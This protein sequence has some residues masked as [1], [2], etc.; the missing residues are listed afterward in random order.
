MNM[1]KVI[2]WSLLL[3]VP[4]GSQAQC[5][6]TVQFPVT[7]TVPDA[8]GAATVIST[9][10]FAGDYAL[11]ALTA[12]QIYRFSSSVATDHITVSTAVA[13]GAVAFGTQPVL[14]TAA[15]TQAY[16]VHFHTNAACGTQSV[17]RTTRVQRVYC[18]AGTTSCG[19]TNESIARVTIGAINNLSGGCGGGGYADFSAQIATISTGQSESITVVNTNP[20]AG[21]QVRVF[22]D[23]NL[24]FSLN[25]AGETY[26]LATTD[27]I[28]FSGS[29]TA[30][31]GTLPGNVRMR[32]RLAYTGTVPTCGNTNF[33]EVEDYTLSVCNSF[34][35][36]SG[37]GDVMFAI[38]PPYINRFGGG[39]GRGDAQHTIQGP[40]PIVLSD[41]GGNTSFC[42]G[43]SFQVAYVPGG[44]HN[45]GN[46]F[47]VQLSNAAGSFT[48]QVPV[49]IGS[50]TSTGSGSIP[51][52]IPV[53]TPAGTGYRLRVVSSNPVRTGFA[54]GTAITVVAGTTW[55]A[56][57]D[58]DGFGNPAATLL[59]C[60]QPNGYVANN[61]DN[62]PT[63]PL[64]T[65]PGICGCGV[66]DCPV[67]TVNVSVEDENTYF[68]NGAPLVAGAHVVIYDLTTSVIFADGFSNAAGVFSSSNIP[69]GTR[70]ISV[71]A[72]GHTSAQVAIAVNSGSTLNTAV[73]IS[74]TSG[75]DADNDGFFAPYD[76]N[77]ADPNINPGAAE[78]CSD[79]LDNDCDGIVNELFI[80]YAD[81]DGDGFGDPVVDSIACSTPVGYVANNTDNCPAV[82][83]V[84]GSACND[85]NANTTNDVLSASC[86]CTGTPTAVT[87]AA[88]VI[89]E[90]PYN[91]TTGLMNDDLRSLGTF[92]LADPY[93]ALG[94]VHTG[95][96]T[97]GPVA[98]AVIAVSGTDAIVDWVLLELR[99]T[100]NPATILASRSALVQRDGD[101]VD[102]DGTSPVSFTIA[103]G[104]YFVAVRHRN[105]LGCMTAGAL[106][107]GAAA[108]SV[109]FTSSALSTFGTNA[110]KPITGT[111]PAQALW[112]GDV[113]FNGQIIY[114]GSTNDR[115]PILVTV[116]STTP[117]NTVSNAYSTRDVNMNGQVKYTGTG[118]DRDPI[119]VN[120][121][122]TT[123]NNVRLQQLP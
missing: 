34:G 2:C 4:A 109:D 98:P 30:P 49:D 118:N 111:I 54:F 8:A 70:H 38:L 99:S 60:S 17:V 85:N 40:D 93:P 97:G 101:V 22:V 39:S 57:V 87:V 108:S 67:G 116:G 86:V 121:G 113:T 27:N 3:L 103:S 100:S 66:Q 19:G 105:H 65:A 110:R 56:D 102:V 16:F 104:N 79:A 75:L 20:F 62:C 51:C 14:Y 94:Y 15:A 52:L 64:K 9:Q 76:C 81:A 12:G 46:T 50:V 28:T 1:W 25:D 80:F 33:G 47:T 58:G 95:S 44:S 106:S 88:R 29:I 77:D 26:A 42:Q 43:E 48:A 32:V 74:R 71:S 120:V 55:Y 5:F 114:T 23:W 83:G 90:G 68:Q 91:S 92:P 112:A 24:N 31:P 119:L 82:A 107:L 10:S 117:N 59:A 89:L 96:G 41:I 35:G 69:S 78:L 18:T 45:P 6:G 21:D 123:P 122:S 84:I 13:S 73:F 11:V 115:D 72:P 53:A 63:D 61:T 36:G 7:T 37:R